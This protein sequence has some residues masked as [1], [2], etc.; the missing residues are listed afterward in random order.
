MRKLAIL[1]ALSAHLAAADLNVGGDHTVVGTQT[2]RV[3]SVAANEQFVA[4][5]WAQSGGGWAWIPTYYA[6]VFD[7]SG[8][9]IT[10]T[11]FAVG[12]YESSAI[13]L[14][15]RE[16]VSIEGWHA[17]PHWPGSEPLPVADLQ[18]FNADGTQR[19]RVELA[20]STGSALPR[21]VAANH[22]AALV[23]HSV[24]LSTV[25]SLVSRDGKVTRLSGDA[26]AKVFATDGGFYVESRPSS[27]TVT[28]V[29]ND[30]SVTPVS[31]G[32]A[33]GRLLAVHDDELLWTS[34]IPLTGTVRMVAWSGDS[35]RAIVR[36]G[37]VDCVVRFHGGVELSRTCDAGHELEPLAGSVSSNFAF[38]NDQ[39]G[40]VLMS[41]GSPTV[42][43]SARSGAAVNLFPAQQTNPSLV[44]HEDG[45]LIAWEEEDNG[46]GR[47]IRLGGIDA[48]GTRRDDV[49]IVPSTVR[50]SHPRLARGAETTLLVFEEANR[51]R[52]M[53]LGTRGI[54][55]GLPFDIGTG[56]EP[57]AAWNGEQ[58][59]VV[60][61]AGRQVV[62]APVSHYGVVLG[63]G[64]PVYPADG[65]EQE[66][67][68]I[69][70]NGRSYV[71][72]WREDADLTVVTADANGIAT[73]LPLRS[74][75]NGSGFDLDVA[76]NGGSCLVATARDYAEVR[77]LEGAVTRVGYSGS[78]VSLVPFRDLFLLVR[79]DKLYDV[80]RAA[81]V[82]GSI[83]ISYAFE[84][85]AALDGDRL[86]IAFGNGHIRAQYVTIGHPR[87]HGV[88]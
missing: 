59:L 48:A 62:A 5:E 34:S 2:W 75:L 82:R 18:W 26:D 11:A 6:R 1:I 80:D 23:C 38:A 85:S 20:K 24:D 88:R 52:G 73:S 9:A 61:H 25:V 33:T 77:T 3:E 30:G 7:A 51:I 8:H 43:P 21:W 71:I 72:A 53:L 87:V 45:L 37:N 49:Q 57:A 76:C 55:P 40:H 47:H 22:D 58:W 46:A 27:G 17:Y 31:T 4:V 15:G 10:R 14:A 69:A 78:G 63:S 68:H 50:Q 36:N 42:I 84:P 64:T 60:W 56:V 29:S 12:Y 44:V 32:G 86:A 65:S 70:A 67:P 28:F 81:A 13:A 35:W 79:A 19:L 66:E 16:L 41:V 83:P 54:D 74:Q 39:S